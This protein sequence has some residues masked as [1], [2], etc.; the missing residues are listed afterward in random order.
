MKL[1][2]EEVPGTETELVLRCSDSSDPEIC[3]LIKYL[4]G[5][6]KRICVHQADQFTMLSLRDILYCE[7]VNRMVFVYTDKD[8]YPCGMSLAQLETKYTNF[9]R[10]SKS[11]V[12][13]IGQIT[14]LKSE[15]HG[16]ILATLSNG[17]QILIS[18][19]YASELRRR[20]QQ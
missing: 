20:L 4:D 2:V 10:C 5:F 12:I 7:F 3:G 16:R 11:T 13:N 6:D 17:E 19:H 14:H 9:F 15:L 18:R 1:T 8:V